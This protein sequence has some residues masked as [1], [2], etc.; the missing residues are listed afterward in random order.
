MTIINFMTYNVRGLNTPTKIHKILKELKWYGPML[1]FLQETHLS[2]ESN[3]KLYSN[4]FPT[5][6]YDDTITKKARGW[7]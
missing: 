4:N 7:Q 3:I 6:Y 2:H 1:I 5:W